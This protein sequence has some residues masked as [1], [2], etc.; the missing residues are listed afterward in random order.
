MKTATD[1]LNPISHKSHSPPT[2]AKGSKAMTISVSARRRKFEVLQDLVLVA[3][4]GDANL[5]RRTLLP[6]SL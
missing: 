3:V 2:R 4:Q 6:I 5:I 1:R